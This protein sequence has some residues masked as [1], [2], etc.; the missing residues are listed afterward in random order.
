[1]SNELQT[2]NT[3]KNTLDSREVA[4]M[5]GKKHG[6]LLKDIQGSGKN[7]GII[8][9]L[10]KGNFP[11]SNYFIESSYKDGSGKTNKCYLVTKMGCEMLGN[12]LQGEKG[13]LFTAKYVER[14]NQMEE[15]IK[16]N[17]PQ[18][19]EKDKLL[20]NLFSDDPMVVSASHKKLV[21]LEVEEAT[22][23]LLETIEKQAPKV[24]KFEQF[25]ETDGTYTFTSV[26]KIIS[27]KVS[28][29]GLNLPSISVQKLTKLLRD[30]DILS[31]NK[32]GGSYTNAPRAGYEEYFNV[33]PVTHNQYGGELSTP[34][35]QTK[36]K[37]CGIEFIYDLYKKN[38]A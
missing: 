5:M 11:I 4:E 24:D 27:T 2:L 15:Q 34:K 26:A 17:K 18:I 23:P 30:N 10:L 19:S 16:N 7:L 22:T 14:F 20:L 9:T 29:D 6:D 37:P 33:T 21:A 38:I 12:K 25:L 35:I 13:I 32:Q 28:E 1:M 8:P 36:V 3:N 31:K